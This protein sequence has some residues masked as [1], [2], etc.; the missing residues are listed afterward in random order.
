[1]NPKDPTARITPEPAAAP[2]PAVPEGRLAKIADL[3]GAC[4]P[5]DM[6]GGYDQCAHGTWP[7]AITQAVWLAQGRDRDQE[8]HAA[9]QAAAP[10]MKAED[11]SGEAHQE[12][13]AAEREGRLPYGEAEAGPEGG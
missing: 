6:A 2:P 5:P 13:L 12:L 9:C 1:M 7:C 3:L 4:P 8:V 10:E 11:A